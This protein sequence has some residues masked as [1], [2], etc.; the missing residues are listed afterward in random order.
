MNCSIGFDGTVGDPADIL[1]GV[2]PDMRGHQ[3]HQHVRGRSPVL[4]ADAPAFEVR[5]VADAV[6]CEQFETTDMHARQYLDWL[7]AVDCREE[8]RRVI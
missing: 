7:V 6:L 3:G 1:G 2:Q 4:H 5:D 8:Q